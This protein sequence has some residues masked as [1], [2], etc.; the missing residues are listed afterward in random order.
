MTRCE[1]VNG[2]ISH[3]VVYCTGGWDEATRV[4]HAAEAPML[5]P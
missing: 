5:R 4:R 3:V 1:V 2:R